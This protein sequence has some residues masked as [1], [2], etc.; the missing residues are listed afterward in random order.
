MY[1]EFSISSISSKLFNLKSYWNI[2]YVSF[3]FFFL[4]NNLK[5]IGI[6]FILV[7][8]I[9]EIVLNIFENDIYSITL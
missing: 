6:F 9:I 2:Y 8:L 5:R 1:S 4:K 7:I 3:F